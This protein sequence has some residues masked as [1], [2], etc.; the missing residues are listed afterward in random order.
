L[1]QSLRA[2]FDRFTDVMKTTKYKQSQG[3]HTLFIK[4]S[5]S[6]GVTAVI[7]YVEDAVVIGNGMEALKNI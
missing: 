6:S 5:T 4:H 7:V 2:W 3:D 1:Q